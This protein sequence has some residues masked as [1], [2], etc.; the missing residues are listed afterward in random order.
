MIILFVALSP[1]AVAAPVFQGEPKTP[2]TSPANRP[3]D[4]RGK[5]DLHIIVSA[6]GKKTLPS[7]SK[8]DLLGNE[9]TCHD[10]QRPQHSIGA[11]GGATFVN[12]PLCKVKLTIYITGFDTKIVSVDLASYHD[13]LR[14]LVKSNGPPIVQ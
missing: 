2:E 10:L 14:I 13:P 3:V 6:Q 9:Q 4:K 8:I 11:D 7:G 1:F 5:L 12:L